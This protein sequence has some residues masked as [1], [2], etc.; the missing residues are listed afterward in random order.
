MDKHV[1]IL[2][3]GPAGLTAAYELCNLGVRS[4][5]LEADAIVGGLARTESYKG[6]AYDIGGH[7]FYSKWPEIKRIWHDLL[8]DDLITVQRV[9]RI[10]YYDR[11]FYY[12]LRPFNAF[13][14]LGALNSLLVTLSY[15]RARLFPSLPEDSFEQYVVNR[16]GRRLY[17][18]F[19]KTYTEKVWGIPCSEI[20]AEWAAQ[21]IRG[22]SFTSA[23]MGALFGTRNSGIRSLIEEFEYPRLG[24]G[25]MWQRCQTEI[26]A[27][28]A[29]VSLSSPVVRIRREGTRI[30][31]VTVLRDGQERTINGSH[32]ISTLALHDL[33]ERIDP[34]VPDDVR[35][36]ACGLHYR[37]FLT[38]VAILKRAEVFPDNWLYIHTPEINAGRI[39]NFKNWSAAM[40]PDPATTSLGLEYF[41]SEG[42][43]LWS[44][45]DDKLLALA[46]RELQA[47]RLAEP[48]DV[49]DGTVKR[50]RKAYPI[51][52]STY[53]ENL[54]IV[55]GYLDSLENFQTVGRNGMHKYNNQDHSMMTAL[56]AARNVCGA[57]HDVW[58]VNTEMEYQEEIRLEAER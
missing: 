25:A 28:G 48:H 23:L 22:L 49:V 21:R 6:Y 56:L 10:R 1:V 18:V 37:D 26:A 24:P 12:P 20:R 29:D 30:V 31:S 14:G 34:P 3:A 32:F 43:A 57:Q 51:Y 13:F 5:I 7:R 41:V 45:P 16:F 17:T 38:V 35:R 52:D 33:I 42:D 53:R 4:T 39:Q 55:R 27:R 15:V 54:G 11:Y 44:M 2:G 36:A 19:F 40:V 50:V 8:G 58:A 9:S 47:M 46:R